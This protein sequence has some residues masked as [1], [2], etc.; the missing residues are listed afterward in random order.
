MIK[1]SVIN[2]EKLEWLFDQPFDVKAML[3][4]QHLE[5][6]KL[7]VNSILEEE[8]GQYAGRRYERDRPYEGRYSRYGYNPG[9]VKIGSEKVRVDVPRIYDKELEKHKSLEH[10]EALRELPAQGEKELQAVLHGLSTRDYS[11]VMQMLSESFGMSSS[12][13]SRSF[14]QQSSEKLEAFE[15]RKLEEDYVALFIDGKSLSGQQMV[16]VLGVTEKGDK[17]PLGVIQATTENAN[18]IAELLRGLIDRGLSFE[19]GILVVI[20]GGKGLRKAVDQVFGHK[21]VVQRCQWHKRENVVSYLPEHQQDLYRKKLQSAYS[22]QEYE[23]AKVRLMKIHQELKTL[24]RSAANSLEEGMEETLTIQRLG[25]HFHFNRS[26]STTNCIENLNSQLGKYLRN[27]K[28]WVNSDQRYRWVVCGMM[29]AEIKMRKV[30]N[31]KMLYQMKE[32]LLEEIHDREV[33]LKQ[34]KAA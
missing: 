10:Y 30:S 2:R 8:V 32:R 16:I 6:C 33:C 11:S 18:S 27:V 19:E 29:E 12:S 25:L 9:S 14:I 20:D 21:A 22:L 5:I 31:Y 4:S 15:K 24:N 17:V 1:N 3:L 13:V 26:F 34:S 7:L 28:R 23:K